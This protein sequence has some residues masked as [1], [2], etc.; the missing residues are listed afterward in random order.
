MWTRGKGCQELADLLAGARA[1][2]VQGDPAEACLVQRADLLISRRLTPAFDLVDTA[3]PLDVEVDLVE[4]VV[5]AV[6]GGPHSTLAAGVAHRLGL[7]LGV[8][9]SVVSAYRSEEDAVGAAGVIE[10]I[11]M[12]VPEVEYRIMQADDM[13]DLVSHFG[14]RTLIVFG[15]P[16]GTWFQRRVSGPGARLR[17]SAPA[18]SVVV[19]SAPRRVF[20]EMGE[21]VFVAPLLQAVDTLLIRSEST[22]AVADEGRLVGLVRRARL[23]EITPDS[24]VSEVMEDPLSVGHREP[25]EAA[26]PLLPVFGPDPIP[27]VDDDQFLVGG[28]TPPAA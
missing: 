22:L 18:G 2:R 11:R 21:P 27:V 25:L 19:Q 12:S 5:A 17:S 7:A 6:A 26:R 28:L 24:P 4:N 14:E 8:P 16:G 9:A 1:H 20:Q 23:A 10:D 3:V 13:S 15:A